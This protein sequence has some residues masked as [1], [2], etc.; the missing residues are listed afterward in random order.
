M[1]GVCRFVLQHFQTEIIFDPMGSHLSS[2]ATFAYKKSLPPSLGETGV[3][4]SGTSTKHRAWVAEPCFE[5]GNSFDFFIDY[6]ICDC[7]FD[8]IIFYCKFDYII[9]DCIFDYIIFNC[10]FVYIICDC[11]NW[12]EFILIPFPVLAGKILIPAQTGNQTMK[13]Y[14]NCKTS[15]SVGDW[16]P[17]RKDIKLLIN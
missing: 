17:G 4:A 8:Y 10:I 11:T 1:F 14:T 13:M 6:I 9:F 7:K 3:S 16:P 5:T 2:Q 12:L 15:L